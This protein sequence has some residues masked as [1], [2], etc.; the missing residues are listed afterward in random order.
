MR[1]E[2][3]CEATPDYAA[4]LCSCHSVKQN[5]SHSSLAF[6]GVFDCARTGQAPDPTCTGSFRLCFR[7][8]KC[9]DPFLTTEPINERTGKVTQCHKGRRSCNQTERHRID[10]RVLGGSKKLILGSVRIAWLPPKNLVVVPHQLHV[11]LAV[12]LLVSAFLLD[13]QLVHHIRR[14]DRRWSHIFRIGFII[15]FTVS[16]G[17]S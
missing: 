16:C 11:Q 12:F 13:T 10:F 5:S 15:G 14:F 1:N 7:L 9:F 8:L 17:C 3:Q 4:P 6:K 2:G